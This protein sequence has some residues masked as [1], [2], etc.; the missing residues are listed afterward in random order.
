MIYPYVGD[1]LISPVP[2]QLSF[3]YCSHKCTYCFANL[4]SPDRSFDVK[5]FQE[6]VK[7]VFHK[8]EK[9]KYT[10]NDTQSVLLRHR[11]PVLISNL[12]DPFAT[13]NYQHAVPAIELLTS[14]KIPVAIQTRGGRGVDDV[15]S[16]LPPSVWYI[17]IPTYNDSIRKEIEPGAPS[18]QSRFKL[19]EDLKAK[20]HEVIVGINPTVSDWLPGA[21]SKSLLDTIKGMGVHGVWLAALHLN[22]KQLRAMPTRDRAQLGEKVIVEGLKNSRD[23]QQSSF[24][25]IDSIKQYAFEIGMEVEGL[26]EGGMSSFFDPFAKVYKKLFPTVH[27]FIN[28]C[29]ANKS[30][31]DPVYYH[32]FKTVM[33]GFPEGKFNIS[34]YMRCMSQT[35]DADFRKEL[36]FSHTYE[37]LLRL[38]WNESRMK[39]MLSRY[40]SFAE[41]VHY[42]GKGPMEWQ[43]DQDGNLVYHF[44]RQFFDDQFVIVT[45]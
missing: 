39:R 1:F 43:E 6:Q 3:N 14:M 21:D 17:S 20:G 15:L 18:I 24:D 36:G 40:W 35:L 27:E 8:N 37:R 32:E 19:I 41:G 28:W 25:F 5:R 2:L 45:K 33:T 26:F 30:D 44:N 7:G 11:Y 16:F 38:S 23:L 13:S 31:G 12:V 22:S 29:H 9:G 4:N 42:D 10:R 34:P